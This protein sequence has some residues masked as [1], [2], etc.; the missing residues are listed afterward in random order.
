MSRETVDR[1]PDDYK[2][3]GVPGSSDR[4]RISAGITSTPGYLKS[5][6]WVR[7]LILA[8]P[9]WLQNQFM[10]QAYWQWAALFICCWG[11]RLHPVMLQRWNRWRADTALDIAPSPA[12]FPAALLQRLS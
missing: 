5:L 12:R 8:G 7:R 2:A 11:R 3:S 9:N 4:A 10:S 6:R 1:I